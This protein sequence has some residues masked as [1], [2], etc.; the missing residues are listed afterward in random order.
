VTP[1]YNWALAFC[2]SDPAQR[3]SQACNHTFGN[4]SAAEIYYIRAYQLN[5][6]TNTWMVDPSSSFSASTPGSVI[7]FDALNLSLL[8]G[9]SDRQD[10]DLKYGPTTAQQGTDGLGPPGMLFLLSA[11]KLSWMTFY[12]LNQI[13]LNRGPGG[14]HYEDNCWSSSAGEFDFLEAPF[15]GGV[16]LPQDRLYASIT[17]GTGRC[18]PV[19]K[20][21]SKSFQR[22]CSHPN[23][24]QMCDCPK[25]M[26]CAGDPHHVG[27]AHMSCYLPNV[28][29]P[30][31]FTEFTVDGNP[32]ACGDYF[33][34]VPG[35][36]QS[37]SFFSNDT[38]HADEVGSSEVIIA[39]VVDGDGV[40][41]Y[42][43]PSSLPSTIWSGVRKFD[44]DD[45]LPLTPQQ[46]IAP[47]PPCVDAAKPCA[48]YLPSCDDECALVSASG[49]FGLTQLA[50]AFAAEAARDHLNWWTYYASTGQTSSPSSPSPLLSNQL[51]MFV[52]IP[53][54]PASLPFT[55]DAQCPEA[56][57]QLPG[58]CTSEVPFVC[59]S[60]SNFHQCSAF[61]DV[62]PL[63]GL[64]TSCCDARSCEVP[65]AA[66]CSDKECA[67]STCD[68]QSQPFYC[69]SGPLEGTCSAEINFLPQQPTCY[70]CCNSLSCVQ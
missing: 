66:Q 9:P 57:C 18:F 28:T 21:V 5:L 42:R 2:N 55:C 39:A 13:T 19:Q 65:C 37:T 68:A 63:S 7:D 30:T 29:V 1:R 23:C 17:S 52:E 24:C 46:P 69:S 62:W 70:A 43:W 10:W 40:T 8:S 50:G 4:T 16:K 32:T 31:E 22:E 41:V 48:V 12:A 54:T 26:V 20:M 25:G 45:T 3:R 27:F 36:S 49:N 47:R 14:E 61:P 34:A 56:I 53:V 38:T 60:G 58:R 11:R 33:A 44:A 15:W 6:E 35:G 64:C 59:L 67:A 51:P